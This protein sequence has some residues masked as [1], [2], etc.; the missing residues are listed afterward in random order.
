MVDRALSGGREPLG[1]VGQAVIRRQLF[2]VQQVDYR[3]ALR[4]V[5]LH[6]PA[7][8]GNG[9]NGIG[10]RYA[11][12]QLVLRQPQRGNAAP[13]PD[14]ALDG[15]LRL[16]VPPAEGKVFGIVLLPDQL[17][18]QP[19]QPGQDVVPQVRV[20]LHPAVKI[21]AHGHRRPVLIQDTVLHQPV[22]HLREGQLRLVCPIGGGA[23]RADVYQLRLHH[24]AGGQHRQIQSG[25]GAGEGGP[26][27]VSRPH[28]RLL[29]Q[30]DCQGRHVGVGR[31]ALGLQRPDCRGHH[32]VGRADQPG[33]V[34]VLLREGQSRLLLIQPDPVHAH[35]HQL[36]R[37]P[38]SV[39]VRRRRPFHAG[40]RQH[41]GQEQHC[42]RHSDGG[43]WKLSHTVFP[44]PATAAPGIPS[45]SAEAPE[46]RL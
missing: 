46:R 17:R 43:A 9:L 13:H 44:P 37:R 5:K 6:Q 1:V 21:P 32:C 33:A 40:G 8:S 29:Q 12:V 24:L 10:R 4:V 36:C 7:V 22:G 31:G 2:D 34:D 35:L 38:L 19:L 25:K 42:R 16:V 18:P 27:P 45:A 30:L 11:A 26:H 41:S 15:A 14:K 3:Q 20:H 23:G 39:T 28:A